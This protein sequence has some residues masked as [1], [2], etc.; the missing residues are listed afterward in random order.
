LTTGIVADFL[1][2]YLGQYIDGFDPK[3]LKIG[4]WKGTLLRLFALVKKRFPLIIT[5]CKKGQIEYHNIKL[6]AD[7][8]NSFSLPVSIKDGTYWL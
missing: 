8:L 7:V 2:R 3:Q 4:I 6:R 1:S 5:L